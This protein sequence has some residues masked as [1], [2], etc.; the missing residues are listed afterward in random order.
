MM[1]Q[2]QKMTAYLVRVFGALMLVA[3]FVFDTTQP[4]AAQSN[5]KI[6]AGDTLRIEVLEDSSLNRDVLVLPDGSVSFPLVGTVAARGQSILQ[7]SQKLAS[8]LASNFAVTPNVF[9]SVNSLAKP[10]PAKSGRV[11]AAPKIDAYVMGE[12]AKPGKIETK[13]GTTILQLLAEAGG[14]TKFAA[15]K[16]IEL[17]RTDPKTGAVTT[18]LFSYTGRGK[19][20]RIPASTPLIEGDV[21][22][23]PERRLFE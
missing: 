7:L 3:A 1:N 13:P 22:V 21:I 4:A 23:V 8:G 16:R 17:R 11:A 10:K 5:Y 19:G 12:I 18:Y 2:R 20:A 15:D 9:V 14:L 6:R